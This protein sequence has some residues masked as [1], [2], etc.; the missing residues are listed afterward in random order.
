M[1]E[2]KAIWGST[3]YFIEIEP[4]TNLF[5]T[6]MSGLVS[7]YDTR[8]LINE[9]DCENLHDLVRTVFDFWST[10]L[11]PHETR[12]A[13]WIEEYLFNMGINSEYSLILRLIRAEEMIEQQ[14]EDIIIESVKIS[15]IHLEDLFEIEKEVGI[16]GKLIK[17]KHIPDDD[18]V[19]N[20][21][22]QTLIDQNQ[23]DVPNEIQSVHQ[24]VL[25]NG[26]KQNVE[27]SKD[28][29]IGDSIGNYCISFALVNRHDDPI[30]NIEIFDQ[31]PYSFNIIMTETNIDNIEKEQIKGEGALHL[32]W[33]VPDLAPKD[34][35]EIKYFLKRRISRIILEVDE[36][37]ITVL[38]SFESVN[39]TDLEYRATTKYVNSRKT[40]LK[41]VFIADTIPPEFNILKTTPEAIAPQGIIERA[42]MKGVTARWSHKNINAEEAI[43]KSYR[44]DFFR[45]LFRGKKLI[46]D[47]EGNDIV[48]CLKIIQPT[49]REIGYKILYVIK[50]L[51]QVDEIISITDKIPASHVIAGQNPSDAQIMEETIGDENKTIS[52]ISNPP[53]RNEEISVLLQVSGDTQPIFELFEVNVGDKKEVEVLKKDINIERELLSYN[54]DQPFIV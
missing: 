27:M 8:D 40:P 49:T 11:P 48:K 50:S 47:N 42:K 35:V 29:S 22:V 21:L 39:P 28:I 33:K 24:Y 36:K 41:A 5:N 15:T 1:V 38:N 16:I 34:R 13:R 2:R 26:E 7:F 51:S 17:L 43:E 31:I 20:E 44:L 6:S 18:Y 37:E 30:T 19:M 25:Q 45:Y 32:R 12:V 14:L 53:R 9:K 46:Q 52:W 23:I 4:N 10:I 54:F 3:R